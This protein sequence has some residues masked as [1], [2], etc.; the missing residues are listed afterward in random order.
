ML[1]KVGLTIL[2]VFLLAF[3][4][5][6]V[7]NL[8]TWV[9]TVGSNGPIQLTIKGVSHSASNLYGPIVMNNT[10][11]VQLRSV[12]PLTIRISAMEPKETLAHVVVL[13][14]NVEL[15]NEERLVEWKAISGS[16][17]VISIGYH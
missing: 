9:V 13:R 10:T 3:L 5:V 12:G 6:S 15:L 11:E 1:W 17:W 2:A 14:D 16:D 7:S 8:P 4:L